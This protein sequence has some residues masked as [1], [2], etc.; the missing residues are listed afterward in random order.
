MSKSMLMMHRSTG[1]TSRGRIG[2]NAALTAQPLVNPW[3]TDPVDKTIL[4]QGLKDIISTV[5]SGT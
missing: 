2:I 3:F 5:P 1:I 4:I